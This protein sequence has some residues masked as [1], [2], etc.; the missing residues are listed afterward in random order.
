MGAC[1]IAEFKLNLCRTLDQEF[2]KH[3]DL[4]SS[5]KH[6]DLFTHAWRHQSAMEARTRTILGPL[7][8]AKPPRGPP[9]ANQSGQDRQQH[10]AEAFCVAH[11]SRGFPSSAFSLRETSAGRI[12]IQVVREM[13]AFLTPISRATYSRGSIGFSILDSNQAWHIV[14]VLDSNQCSSG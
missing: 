8:Q 1:G 4:G 5:I 7:C 10:I 9:P 11:V 3:R 13:P 6:P 12:N 14:G 2:R